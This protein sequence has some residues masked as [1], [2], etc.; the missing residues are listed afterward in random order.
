MVRAH[1]QQLHAPPCQRL[2]SPFT[3]GTNVWVHARRFFTDTRY[4]WLGCTR[5]PPCNYLVS[6]GLRLLYCLQMGFYLQAR[7]AVTPCLTFAC[8]CTRHKAL[9][10][11]GLP[12]KAHVCMQVVCMLHDELVIAADVVVM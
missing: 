11:V 9:F 2:Y 10:F 8:L 3:A 7:S 1:R 4:F 12:A 5:F 6:R